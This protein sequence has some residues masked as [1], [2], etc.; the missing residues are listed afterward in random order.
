MYRHSHMTKSDAVFA[1]PQFDYDGYIFVG[2]AEKVAE[3][4]DSG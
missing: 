2:W 3:G 1:E 4:K